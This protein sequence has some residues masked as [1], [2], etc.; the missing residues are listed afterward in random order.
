[1]KSRGEKDIPTIHDVAEVV[2]KTVEEVFG[3]KIVH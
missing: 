3:V 2:A 1:M